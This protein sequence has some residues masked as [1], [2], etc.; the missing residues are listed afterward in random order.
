MSEKKIIKLTYIL[1]IISLISKVFGFIRD[2]LIAKNFGAGMETD[3]YFIALVTSTILFAIVSL[4]L[5][6]TLI[7]MIS[8]VVDKE[9]KKKRNPVRK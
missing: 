1:V 8:R 6:T 5:T 3:V 7:P 9:G 4:A 2:L